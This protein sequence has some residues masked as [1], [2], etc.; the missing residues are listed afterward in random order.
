M[1]NFNGERYWILVQLTA[2]Y[3]KRLLKIYNSKCSDFH[4]GWLTKA[5]AGISALH[6]KV[7][8]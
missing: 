2:C 6:Y 8:L 5:L 7:F 1:Y 4:M 3:D